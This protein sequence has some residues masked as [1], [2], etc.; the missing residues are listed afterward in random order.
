MEQERKKKEA[1]RPA[2]PVAPRAI[3]CYSRQASQT[4]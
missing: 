2:D 1:A 3:A 4:N